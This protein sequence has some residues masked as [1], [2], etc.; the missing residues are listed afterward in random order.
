MIKMKQKIKLSIDFFVQSAIISLTLLGMAWDIFSK[1]TGVSIYYLMG[2]FVI[3]CWQL[4]SALFHIILNRSKFHL[5]YLGFALCFLV[6]VS[7]IVQLTSALSSYLFVGE[8]YIA[9]VF[10]LVIPT[11]SAGFYYIMTLRDIR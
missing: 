3:G 4:C 7:A 10:W 6:T 1:S 8:R 9:T 2:L 11:F 5:L